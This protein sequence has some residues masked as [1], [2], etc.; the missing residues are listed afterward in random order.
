MPYY[1]N[2]DEKIMV[3]REW[4]DL[5][6]EQGADADAFAKRFCETLDRMTAEA[7]ELPVDPELQAREPDE[8]DRIR[9]FRP[10]GPRVL[11]LELTDE[12]LEDRILGAWLG[13]GAGCMLGVPCEGFSRKAIKAA[14]YA[15]D[16]PY[17]LRDY[18]TRHPKTTSALD[19]YNGLPFRRFL[20]DE[21]QYMMPDDDL[22]YTLLGLVILEQYGPGF[23]S[24]D[25]GKA[26][27][28]YVPF[29]C[30]AEKVALDNLRNGLTPP[31]TAA[32]NNPDCEWLG[33]DIRSDPWG[34]AA[35]GIPELAAEFAYRDARVSHLRN[36]IYGA[37]FFSAVIAAVIATSDIRRS[38]EI[39]LTEIPA[40]CRLAVGI[41]ETLAWCDEL[42]DYDAVLDRIFERYKG[43]HVGHTINNAALVVAGLIL[44]RDDFEVCITQVVMAGMDTDCTGATAGS[45]MGALWGAKNLPDKWIK[46]LGS[47]HRSY[48]NGL[49]TW[50]NSDIAR[51]F[52]KLALENRRRVTG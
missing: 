6:K 16:I 39:G 1:S 12:E 26:W 48:L 13:R 28:D 47:V 36:G 2:L 33:A 34:Y 8:L 3:L 18:W 43:M 52:T 46:P 38:I 45:I 32:V 5:K 4:M 25:V 51:R 22:L 11:D 10:D 27:L 49:Y 24:E 37:M 7:S 41:R 15:L 9:A 31:E 44:A 30:T 21:I 40:E 20:K 23:T 14:C 35:P 42:N 17:P 19:T 50:D 29:A